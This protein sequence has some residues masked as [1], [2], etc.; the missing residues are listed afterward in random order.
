MLVAKTF[1][2]FLVHH[3]FLGHFLKELLRLVAS[4][5]GVGQERGEVVARGE[6]RLDFGKMRFE[7][8][9]NIIAIDSAISCL[10]FFLGISWSFLFSG[11]IFVDGFSLFSNGK[12]NFFNGR[13]SKC[14]SYF[15]KRSLFFEGSNLFSSKHLLI[16]SLCFSC[17]CSFRSN[18]WFSSCY[19]HDLGFKGREKL[20]F[21]LNPYRF[22]QKKRLFYRVSNLRRD[23]SFFL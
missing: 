18:C 17:N 8:S 20:Y 7:N 6:V 1:D 23:R 4:H 13:S 21:L 22:L 19:L 10:L 9:H 5:I 12:S 3:S 11:M 15:F 2:E 16:R 14:N